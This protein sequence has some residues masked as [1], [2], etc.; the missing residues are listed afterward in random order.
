MNNKLLFSAAFLALVLV[1]CRKPKPLDIAIPQGTERI[2]I[3]SNAINEHLIVVSAGY[4][5]RPTANMTTGAIDSLPAEML[6]DSAHVTINVPNETPVRLQKLSPGIFSTSGITL[7][8]DTKYE[9]TVT[10]LKKGL[11]A[12]ATTTYVANTNPISVSTYNTGREIDSVL[13]IDL[14]IA[15]TQTGDCFF[16]SYSTVNQLRKA[17]SKIRYSDPVTNLSSLASFGPKQIQLFDGGM[18]KQNKIEGSFM[19][20]AGMGDTLVVQVAKIDKAYYK[21]LTAYKRTGYF[22]NQLTG[23]PINLPSNIYTGYGYFA[24]YRPKA[25]FFDVT[26]GKPMHLSGEVANFI[27]DYMH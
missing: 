14:S 10:D 23:E 7:K 6:I 4:S 11:I 24:L 5:M 19:A 2:V 8:P 3:S 16:V 17:V 15:E 26:T 22:I 27:N 1:G 21:Y 18:A 12:T 25:L 9:L 13:S 20:K